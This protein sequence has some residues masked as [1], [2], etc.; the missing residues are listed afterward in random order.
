LPLKWVFL[1]KFNKDGYL[2]KFKARL[3]V[4]G[5]LQHKYRDI[6]AATLVARVF[7]LLIAIAAAFSLQAY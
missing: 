1:Y 5:D 6:Y 7:R 3:V 2:Y 4:R